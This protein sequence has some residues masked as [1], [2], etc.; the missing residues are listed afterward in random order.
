MASGLAAHA[1]STRPT[2]PARSQI[3][4]EH[5]ELL[6]TPADGTRQPVRR[7]GD[8]RDEPPE[9]EVERPDRL[10]GFEAEQGEYPIAVE[11]AERRRRR[12]EG[13]HPTEGRVAI[14]E[15]GPGRPGPDVPDDG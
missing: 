1:A 5:G 9:P 8:A 12:V 11:G 14:Q 4:V 7:E 15:F 10:P 2:K 13:E 3:D 6:V